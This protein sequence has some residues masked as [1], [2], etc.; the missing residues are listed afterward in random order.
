MISTSIFL[1]K[2]YSCFLFKNLL[3]YLYPIYKPIYKPLCKRSD[4][5]VKIRSL[6]KTME[7]DR[8]LPSWLNWPSI[9]Y[10][11]PCFF[12]MWGPRFKQAWELTSKKKKGLNSSSNPKLFK[13]LCEPS[14]QLLIHGICFSTS[15]KTPQKT[16]SEIIWLKENS[17][18]WKIFVWCT[19]ATLVHN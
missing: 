2:I 15:K 18:I 12:L 14:S 17:W 6:F 19:V 11:P 13:S 3:C 7:V 9:L 16:K 10:K 5:V 8:D 1:H 4:Q